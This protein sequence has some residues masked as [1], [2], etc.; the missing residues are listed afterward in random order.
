MQIKVRGTQLF[1]AVCNLDFNA[2]LCFLMISSWRCCWDFKKKWPTN[3]SKYTETVE[4]YTHKL[5]Q[6]RREEPISENLNDC[7]LQ[8]LLVSL[9]NRTFVLPLLFYFTGK[10]L[11]C[12]TISHKAAL[13]V[14][15]LVSLINP[16]PVLLGRIREYQLRRKN[17]PYCYW[18]LDHWFLFQ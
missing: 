4:K 3:S 14:F 18:N 13:V 12:F 9:L 1:P 5:K 15:I 7:K 6:K 2:S 17:K 16:L 8:I 11:F 10:E